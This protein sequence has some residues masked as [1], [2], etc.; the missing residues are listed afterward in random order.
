[1]PFFI[2]ITI[3]KKNYLIKQNRLINQFFS[4][5]YC[6][7]KLKL[8][9]MVR[10]LCRH[11]KS[12][13]YQIYQHPPSWELKTY[14]SQLSFVI[15]KCKFS[16]RGGGGHNLVLWWSDRPGNPR[17]I[18]SPNQ[19]TTAGDLTD[20]AILG[21]PFTTTENTPRG[22][23]TDPAWQSCPVHPFP[24]SSATGYLTYPATPGSSLPLPSTQPHV[25]W[26]TRLP[27]VQVAMWTFLQFT[28]TKY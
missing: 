19:H 25:I 6:R 17:S 24:P 11:Y 23:L 22:D 14:S 5:Q 4:P 20:P 18:S 9:N 16:F 1:M 2:I 26:P 28:C 8:T 13:N 21:Y 12:I 10:R 3:Y 27:T 7:F 15:D